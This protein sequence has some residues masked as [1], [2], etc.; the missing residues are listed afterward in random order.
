[1]SDLV[2]FDPGLI[3]P[4]AAIFRDGALVAA[5]RVPVPRRL[6]KDVS[7]YGERSRQ[8]AALVAEW[9]VQ[10]L[11]RDYTHQPAPP[12]ELVFERP[13]IYRAGRS[14]GDPNDLIPLAIIAGAVS[15]ILGCRV[16]APT[17][18][19]WTGGIE[20]DEEGDPWASPRGQRVR[21]R[22]SDAEF[23]TI[24][25]SHDAIDAVGLGL[26]RLGRFERIRAYARG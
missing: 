23:A 20:K 18:R 24:T 25:P 6:A 8:V 14:K 12:R 21:R 9:V 11:V 7:D 26:W 19:E 16:C 13:Q 5:S 17:P 3:H 4:A 15:G 10:R 22:L 2:A 1:V